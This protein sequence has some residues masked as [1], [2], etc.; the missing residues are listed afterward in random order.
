MSTQIQNKPLMPEELFKSVARIYANQFKV[1]GYKKVAKL[2][3]KEHPQYSVSTKRVKNFSAR[4]ARAH[5]NWG[6]VGLGAEGNI[7]FRTAVSP[8]P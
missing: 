8:R 3:Q 5:T 4:C 6:P 1:L 7:S 2:V